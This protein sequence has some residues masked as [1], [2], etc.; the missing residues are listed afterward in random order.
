MGCPR[1]RALFSSGTGLLRVFAVVAEP[2]QPP[3][4]LVICGALCGVHKSPMYTK[5]GSCAVYYIIAFGPFGDSDNRKFAAGVTTRH[6]RNNTLRRTKGGFKTSSK[7]TTNRGSVR[8]HPPLL[9]GTLGKPLAPAEKRTR[10]DATSDQ[11]EHPRHPQT[12][13]KRWVG[14]SSQE[15][16]QRT[17][18]HRTTNIVI[19]TDNK[20][21]RGHI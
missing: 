21:Q 10:S 3:R 12:E 17:S 9:V 14:G 4:V 19:G 7:N 6:I 2:R 18:N 20:Q 13:R 15:Q 11:D 1:A 16:A 8:C 5:K